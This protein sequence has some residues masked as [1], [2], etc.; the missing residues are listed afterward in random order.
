MAPGLDA[1]GIAPISPHTLFSRPLVVSASETIRISLPSD[2]RGANLY[3]DGKLETAMKP[4]SVVEIARA[5]RPVKFARLDKHHFFTMLER[6]LHWGTSL[7]R[8][9]E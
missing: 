3:A 7:K 9:L 5:S 8:S 1:F 2:S 4:G 6:K